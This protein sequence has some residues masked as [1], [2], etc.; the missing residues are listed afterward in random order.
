MKLFEVYGADR[1]GTAWEVAKLPAAEALAAVR[2]ARES[3]RNA[4]FGISDPDEPERGDQEAAIE[5]AFEDLAETARFLFGKPP[6]EPCPLC[7]YGRNGS[8]SKGAIEWQFR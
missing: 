2:L 3:N 5:E 8:G 7:G 1:S 4:V 6:E